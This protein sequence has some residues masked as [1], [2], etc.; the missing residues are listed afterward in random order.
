MPCP[1]HII[2]ANNCPYEPLEDVLNAVN[3]TFTEGK[4]AESTIQQPTLRIET[5]ENNKLVKFIDPTN[6]DDDVSACFVQ[7][8]G[9]GAKARTTFPIYFAA[10]ARADK[11]INSNGEDGDGGVLSG[12]FFKDIN[13]KRLR[14]VVDRSG[15]MSAYVM[16]G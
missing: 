7:N 2:D 8:V 5:D 14:F 4:T 15:S 3:Y 16:W 6:T 11:Q 10:F 9:S 1:R 12:A 13:S